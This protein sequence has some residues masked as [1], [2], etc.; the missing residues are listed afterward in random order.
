MNGEIFRILMVCAYAT[1]S[2][3]VGTG[4]GGL[5]AFS[6]KHRG[7]VFLSFVL[8][9]SAGMMLSVVCFDLM[10]HAFEK[11]SF[12][13]CASGIIAGV[14]FVLLIKKYIEKDGEPSRKNSMLSTGI[15]MLASIALH[16]FPEG[17]AI[18]SGFDADMKLGISL[19][20][21][22]LLHDIPEGMALALPLKAGG[23][24]AW[25]AALA[26]AASGLPMGFGGLVGVLLGN[27]SDGVIAFCLSSA[28]GAMLFVVVADLIPESK[29]I[30]RGRISSVGNILGM[31][32]G[33]LISTSL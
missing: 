10:P 25:K 26:A 7:N 15:I 18:G 22:I 31:L 19:S 20:I 32:I 5:A 17:L 6:L 4:L 33:M 23:W 2:G 24:P 28:G 14:A 9:F 29:Y 13:L 8:E 3:I 11:A 30:Y 27:V 16:N 1:V 21:V 12:P